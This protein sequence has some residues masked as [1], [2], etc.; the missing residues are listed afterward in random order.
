MVDREIIKIIK[1]SLYNIL[2]EQLKKNVEFLTYRDDENIVVDKNGEF[3]R[4]ATSQDLEIY[5]KDY[6]TYSF[7]QPSKDTKKD[8]TVSFRDSMRKT[9]GDYSASYPE[10]EQS[11]DTT[12]WLNM[13]ARDFILDFSKNELSKVVPTGNYGYCKTN[14]IH[15]YKVDSDRTFKGSKS[16]YQELKNLDSSKLFVCVP[17]LDMSKYKWD[18]KFNTDEGQIGWYQ[19]LQLDWGVTNKQ[20][21]EST[22]NAVR[23]EIKVSEGQFCNYVDKIGEK[24]RESVYHDPIEWFKDPHNLLTFFEVGT[25]FI[26]LVG[27]FL[28]AGFGLGN[29]KLYWDEGKKEDAALS[30]FF[31]VLPGLGEIG[32]KIAMGF[33][34]EGLETLSEKIIKKGLREEV[35]KGIRNPK[36]FSENIKLISK[37]LTPNE[38]KLLKDVSN[39]RK[40]LEKVTG[41]MVKKNPKEFKSLLL[42]KTTTEKFLT[43]TSDS[44]EKTAREISKIKG[45][46]TGVDVGVNVGGVVG[47]MVG[48][49]LYQPIR[50]VVEE[51]GYD[52]NMVKQSFGVSNLSK[53]DSKRD[54]LIL[55][56]AWEG[57]WRPGEVVPEKYQTKKYFNNSINQEFLINDESSEED[58]ELVKM[59][60]K[61]GWKPGKEMPEKYW[62]SNIK[63]NKDIEE[64]LK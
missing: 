43:T 15:T 17:Q 18:Y 10:A 3:I 4:N 58:K 14:H 13:W 56:K 63:I 21:L 22:W 39:S 29:A 30:A 40:Y 5:K 44:F 9:V 38:F 27:P 54:N 6:K 60:L 48:S 25:A 50:K 41:D 34:R 2:Q 23:N 47:G 62:T 42:N 36:E 20:T 57:G 8:N 7:K 37:N 61:D 28:S 32:G 33:T 31:S 52:W 12:M 59:A 55:K 45:V 11:K 19:L 26:P 46:R 35:L 16:L 24:C 64:S 51:E 1:L 49:K 53:E